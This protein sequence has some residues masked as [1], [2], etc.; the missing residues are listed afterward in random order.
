MFSGAN[1]NQYVALMAREVHEGKQIKATSLAGA[2]E[3]DSESEDEDEN[4][5]S[6]SFNNL[7]PQDDSQTE[8]TLGGAEG[9]EDAVEE[10]KAQ[11]LPTAVEDGA[12]GPEGA[13]TRHNDLIVRDE[14]ENKTAV[15]GR[16]KLPPGARPKER[17]YKKPRGN[18]PTS[19]GTQKVLDWCYKYLEERE[20]QCEDE[21]KTIENLKTVAASELKKTI[22][23][24]HTQSA[25]QPGQKGH[26][27]SAVR[28]GQE[29]HT[30]SAVRPGQ[31][32]HTQSAVR[33]GQEG[34]TRSAVRPGQEGH[35]QS[36]VRLVQE[37]HTQ[38]AVRPGQ[39]GHTQS[40]VRP[41]KEG[42]LNWSYDDY[43]R[44]TN[45]F[46]EDHHIDSGGQGEVFYGNSFCL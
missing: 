30:Q 40:S 37:G 42:L 33:L 23:G 24:A 38:S 16:S 8:N 25:M 44:M 18:V 2:E 1:D 15:T 20:S 9:S 32:G 10:F 28:P 26:S 27:Q 12:Q 13:A 7:D 39:E 31:E 45:N 14:N 5:G 4:A 29:G 46:D 41:G 11:H 3:G 21:L 34:H 17:V 36:A 6:S 22:G 43:E 19:K 35:S